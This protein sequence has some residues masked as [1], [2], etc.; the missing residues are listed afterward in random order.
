MA[1]IQDSNL[2][3]YYGWNY[4]EEPWNSEMDKNLVILGGM[5]C[6]S[7]LSATQL[8]PPTSNDGDVYF[9]PAGATGVWAGQ[10][11]SI[12][13]GA[14]LGTENTGRAFE[15]VFVPAK[16][17][18]TFTVADATDP[19]KIQTFNG[20]AIVDSI[21]LTNYVQQNSTY[22]HTGTITFDSPPKLNALHTADTSEL[23]SIADINAAIA[24]QTFSPFVDPLTAQS[25]D[26]VKT[27]VHPK[28]FPDGVALTDAVSLGQAQTLISN[29]NGANV[30]GFNQLFVGKI[31]D[32]LD[33]RTLQSSDASVTIT[34]NTS[35]I[36]LTVSLP[37][38]PSTWLE[39]TDTPAT[40]AAQA[41]MAVVVNSVENAL[42]FVTPFAET[43]SALTDVDGSYAGQAGQLVAVNAT[44]T[45]LEFVQSPAVIDS[46]LGLIDTPNVYTG[47]NW[48]I[49]I[50]AFSTGL[51]AVNPLDVMIDNFT[52]LT[53]TPTS[54]VGSENYLVGVNAAGT[55][56]E[57]KLP[58]AA[59]IT[60][61]VALND[62]PNTYAGQAGSTVVVNATEDGLEFT[63]AG[64]ANIEVQDEGVS[65]GAVPTLNFIGS[66]VTTVY[67][68]V[69][70][71]VDI[72]IPSV[73]LAVQSFTFSN[74]VSTFN[75]WD[76]TRTVTFGD[77]VTQV[78]LQWS[79]NTD[80]NAVT[81]QSITGFGDGT[82][83]SVND[84][85]VTLSGFSITNDTTWALNGQ[86][87]NFG[88]AI[89]NLTLNWSDI[90]YTGKLLQSTIVVGDL[91]S[92]SSN[93]NDNTIKTYTVSAGTQP[94]YFYVVFPT[95]VTAPT[96]WT[97]T[98][99]GFDVPFTTQTTTM[100]VTNST[101]GDA[102]NYTVQRS[103][104]AFTGG[105]TFTAS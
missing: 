48:L 61:F 66:D 93:P 47:A 5:A 98:G 94:E 53:D 33:F 1:Y 9:V 101:T 29:V 12:A 41:G 51:E 105:I 59:G 38:V 60:D 90:L 20:S 85:T 18:W 76:G 16:S 54:Y 30:G 21:D 62:T 57:Y 96:T 95:S 13:I 55:A 43:Y 25:I 56:L 32:V 42:E 36:D 45:G 81:S 72:Y 37:A 44:E 10:D 22:N 49:R 77:A 74:V 24:S 7:V 88:P 83:P 28:T 82:Q 99:T 97:D 65:L 102:Q 19:N 14:L 68:A 46:F 75:T 39:L 6:L 15:W 67:N 8:T 71:R 92:L 73:N 64:S 31:G 91:A 63:P 40:Y 80:P 26:G 3:L 58:S 89:G 70:N 50:N 23:A 17:G 27:F 34:Q 86:S 87:V 52:G 100:N 78:D 104:N 4:G 69:D 103:L 11:N 35:D 2:T 84:R 79:Y